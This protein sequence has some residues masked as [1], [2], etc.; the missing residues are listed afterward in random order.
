MRLMHSVLA[1]VFFASVF[2]GV[3]ASAQA[4]TQTPFGDTPGCSTVFLSMTAAGG[5]CE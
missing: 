5:S 2:A 3:C 1:V 4:R